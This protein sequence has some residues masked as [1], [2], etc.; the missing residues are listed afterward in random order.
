[1]DKEIKEKLEELVAL[2]NDTEATVIAKEVEEK[3]EKILALVQDPEE[4]AAERKELK[5]KLEKVVT[6]VGNASVDPD[7]ETE[8]C[9]ADGSDDPHIL[10]KYIVSEYTQPTRKIYLRST[11]LRRNTAEDLA[12]QITFSIEEFKG[13]I[14]SVEMG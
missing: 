6:L 1:M 2:M 11:T 3:L 13:E 9:A 5:E 14:D 4:S 10:V 8:Y 7:I 12:N